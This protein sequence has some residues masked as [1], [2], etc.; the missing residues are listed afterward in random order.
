MALGDSQCPENSPRTWEWWDWTIGEWVLDEEATFACQ[1]DPNPE[2]G[3]Q[4]NTG[5]A[6]ANCG[7]T[8]DWNGLTYCCK[9]NCNYGWINVDPN[10]DPLCQC[11]IDKK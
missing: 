6:C 2:P 4:C 7:L 5:S 1:N 10:T 3:E 11:G 8:V 9:T